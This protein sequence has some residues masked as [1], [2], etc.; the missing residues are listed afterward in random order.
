MAGYKS[1]DMRFY[2]SVG[3]GSADWMVNV[4]IEEEGTALGCATHCRGYVLRAFS[5]GSWAK[6]QFW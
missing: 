6:E 4:L 1:L 2:C 3:R 5:P